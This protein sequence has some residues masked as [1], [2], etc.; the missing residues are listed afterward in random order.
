MSNSTNLP[1][2]LP[3]TAPAWMV[4][5][6]QG[7]QFVMQHPRE[8]I[9]TW[10]NTPETFTQGQIFP[11]RVEFVSAEADVPPGFYVGGLNVHHGPFMLFSGTI[12]EMRPLVYRDLQ[13]FYGSH[14][15]DMRLIRP[16]RLQFWLDD[17]PSGGILL[18]GQI[19]SFVWR[20]FVTI[21][22]FGQRLFWQSFE[23][24]ARQSVK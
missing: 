18:R 8:A 7:H 5:H 15:F 16:T 6:V 23:Q 22:T 17:H 14:L 24:F 4:P 12:S 19:D 1:N 3:H 11:Y 10:L 21:W 2:P 13:Y 9:W 20:H